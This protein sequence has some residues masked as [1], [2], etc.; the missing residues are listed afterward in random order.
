VAEEE[1]KSE[2]IS[3]AHSADELVDIGTSFF[4]QRRPDVARL[5][6][7]A[8]L[9]KE[10]DHGRALHNLSS[11]LIQGHLL[12][13]ALST[14]RR[15]LNAGL[16]NPGVLMNITAALNGLG[17]FEEVLQGTD[18]ILREMPTSDPR[19]PSVLHNRGLVLN[20]LERLEEAV[21]AYDKALILTNASD[22][23]NMI[24]SDRALA[25]LGMGKIVEGCQAYA[26]RWENRLYKS[27]VWELGVPQWQGEDLEGKRIILQHE[28]GFGDGVMLGR[29]VPELLR[30]TPDVALAVPGPLVDLFIN[31]VFWRGVPVFEWNDDE[32]KMKEWKADY[33]VPM[34]T[35]LGLLN[36]EPKMISDEPYLCADADEDNLGPKG[37]RVGICWASGYHNF[38]LAIRRRY[39]PLHILFP[40]AEIPGVRLVSLQKDEPSKDILNLGAESFIHDAMAK[41][42]DFADTA[43][44][45][46]GLDLVVAVDSVVAHIA[47][48]LGVPCLMLGPY[49]RCWRWWGSDTGWPWYKN[50]QIFKQEEY[51]NWEGIVIELIDEVKYRVDVSSSRRAA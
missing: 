43:R 36:F 33:H 47:G 14:A 8:A 3:G 30:R 25:L 2:A 31:H 44:V 10:P 4:M 48:A 42:G 41:C 18:K 17:R 32:E 35:A 39:V 15:A 29:F 5:Y 50:F 49:V 51:G 11:S 24:L 38:A 20:H 19:L 12:Q 7:D 9:L 28:Q 26:V 46:A 45:I 13:A 1:K 37:Y 6:F 40:L 22:H 34:L 16:D 27:K 23:R 21:E